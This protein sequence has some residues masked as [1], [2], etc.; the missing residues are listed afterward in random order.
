MNEVTI[1]IINPE[2]NLVVR[3]SVFVDD[4]YGHEVTCLYYDAI[5]AANGLLPKEPPAKPHA[6]PAP[7]DTAD[8]GF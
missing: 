7:L 1:E 4:L 6:A 3:K 8:G 5:A 2:H